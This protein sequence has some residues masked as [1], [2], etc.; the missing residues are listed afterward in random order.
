MGI[1]H[2]VPAAALALTLLLFDLA[3]ESASADT[4]AN[5]SV[6]AS[7]GIVPSVSVSVC[8][9]T[10]VFGS[11][12][13]NTGAA[14]AGADPGVAATS[15]GSNPGEGVFYLWTA[16]CS[17]GI[18][19][20]TNVPANLYVCGTENGGP[21]ASPAVMLAQ[22]D[23]RFRFGLHPGSTYAEM[24]TNTYG[25]P[26]CPDAHT[27]DSEGEFDFDLHFGLRIDD[28]DANGDFSSV[29]TLNIVPR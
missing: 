16:Q 29:I 1:H 19:I 24:L 9:D 4:S 23:L 28:G 27:V 7:I 5:I 11:G 2:R 25:V 8:D 21:N 17:P 10:V 13:T 26:A 12:L 15:E 14:P 6:T 20:A 18:H 22:S 3:V